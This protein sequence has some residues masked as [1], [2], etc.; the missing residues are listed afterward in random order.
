M[1]K[2][3]IFLRPSGA[4]LAGQNLGHVGWGFQ[5]KNGL[6]NVGSVENPGGS[7]VAHPGN[8]GFWQKTVN[9]PFEEMGSRVSYHPRYDFYK[10]I[11][12]ANFNEDLA[13]STVEWVSQQG[14]IAAKA[15]CMDFVFRVLSGYGANLPDPSQLGNWIPN[16]WFN[17]VQPENYYWIMFRQFPIDIS[18]YEDINGHGECYLIQGNTEFK[19]NRNLHD[20]G[21]GDKVSSIALRGGCLAVYQ[22]INFL[23][24]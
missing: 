5:L 14:Y 16:D 15:N 20:K 17:K 4:P 2:A 9:N 3:Y 11:E 22:D 7:P 24:N 21:W 1:A 10:E 19:Y 18:M 6:V 23:Q 8:T 13:L 12:V